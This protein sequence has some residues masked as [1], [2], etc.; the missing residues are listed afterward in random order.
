[1]Q[2]FGDKVR[3]FNNA[4]TLK[5]IKLPTPIEAMNPFQGDNAALIDKVTGQF[6]GKFYGDAQPRHI[7]FGINP[8]RHGAGLTGTP[9]TDTKRL[10]SECGIEVKEISSHEMSSVFVYDV[11]NAM[12]GPR[13]FY[14]HFYILPYKEPLDLA[15]TVP[16]FVA[17]VKYL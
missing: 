16:I 1:M 6:Y 14:Q 13:A 5:G 12:G 11:I 3:S 8:G 15:H 2:S 9:F 4:L 7:I 17:G 10:L